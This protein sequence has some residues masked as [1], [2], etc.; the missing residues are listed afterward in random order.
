MRST[1]LRAIALLASYNEERFIAGCL[2]HLAQNGVETYLLD[3]ESTDDTVRIAERYLGTGLID[4]ETVPR[5]GIYSWQPILERKEQ[6]AN[7][8]EADWFVNMDPDEIRISP[9][10]GVSLIEAFARVER[11]GFNAV[12]FQEFTFIPTREQPD[13]DH[14]N[15]RATM[16]YYYPFFSRGR[17]IKAWKRQNNIV[18]FAF[19]AAHQVDFDGL[20]VCPTD[21]FMKHYLFLSTEQAVRKYVR[22]T[23]DPAE[24]GRGWHRQRANLKPELIKLPPAE[25]LRHFVSDHELDSSAPRARHYLFDADWAASRHS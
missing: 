20:K 24:L 6:L 5:N 21:F 9:Y 19:S 25:E 14:P 7:S 12:N 22:K 1:K 3:N 16:L 10:P 8:L 15:F 2:E 4:I 23:Y 18:K 11:E 17:Q 13:H